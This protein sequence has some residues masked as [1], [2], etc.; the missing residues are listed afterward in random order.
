MN[1]MSGLNTQIIKS[2]DH[3]ISSQKLVNQI[4]Q[5]QPI[6]PVQPVQPVQLNQSVSVQLN[7]QISNQLNQP[8]SNQLNQTVPVQ[9]NQPVPVQ[10]NQT[11]QI[12]QLNQ[13]VPVQLKVDQIQ[14]QIPAIKLIEHPFLR[15]TQ[16]KPNDGNKVE[17]IKD[18]D[19]KR[20]DY[21]DILVKTGLIKENTDNKTINININSILRDL[22]I[23]KYSDIISKK[24]NE[25]NEIKV[26]TPQYFITD[27]IDQSWTIMDI[28]NKKPIE[29]WLNVFKESYNDLIRISNYIQSIEAQGKVIYP[30]KKNIFRALVC[31]PLNR[32]KVVIFG[33]D[34]Y[35]GV[36]KNT[37][38]PIA[39][40][41]S[42]STDKINPIPQSLANVYKVLQKTVAN[43][44]YPSHADLTCWAE[45][46]V[47]LLNKCLT[48]DSGE[49]S[50]H[51]DLWGEFVTR[52]IQHIDS[53][54]PNCVYLLW[55]NHAQELNKYIKSKNVLMTSHPSNQG[56][57]FGFYDCNHFNETNKIL[58]SWG[59]KEINWNVN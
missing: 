12:S 25:I 3:I 9:L 36:N 42:F 4:P 30:L 15:N 21:K 2:L 11:N 24:I 8:V 35:P 28:V 16:N 26:E 53:T 18:L 7:Q 46:G 27:D 44:S 38:L 43:F 40:G 19:T 58:T 57:R 14:N 51:K 29:S 37:R 17:S 54:N 52:I 1:K 23:S 45:Q 13:P 50:S 39:H 34:P 22:D 47:L 48:L 10:L 6:Q 56:A 5:T 31:T 32:V 59:Q 41:L 49:S 33:Q 20:I 55:G